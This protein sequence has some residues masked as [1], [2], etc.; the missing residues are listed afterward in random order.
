M[1]NIHLRHCFVKKG[2]SMRTF[3]HEELDDNGEL[4]LE[5]YFDSCGDILMIYSYSP[6]FDQMTPIDLDWFK[7]QR[8]ERFD[9][10]EQKTKAIANS[11]DF[12]LAI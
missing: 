12:G 5:I 9:K 2:D 3:L 1:K 10:L 4:T 11:P 8:S 6:Y 7:S